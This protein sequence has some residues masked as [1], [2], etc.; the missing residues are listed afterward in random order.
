MKKIIINFYL[1]TVL[2]LIAQAIFV[3]SSGNLTIAD[4]LQV[5]QLQAENSKL[6][7]EIAVLEGKIVQAQTVK[8]AT[9]NLENN[10]FVS[11]DNR[12]TITNKMLAAKI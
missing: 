12:E 10:E 11:I 6:T 3:V 2:A 1:I 5:K 8:T 4:S 7:E 9:A